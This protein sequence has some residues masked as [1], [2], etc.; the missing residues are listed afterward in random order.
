MVSGTAA[1]LLRVCANIADI[2]NSHPA[3]QLAAAVLVESSWRHGVELQRAVDLRAITF[4]LHLPR[5]E[6]R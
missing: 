5:A 2:V 6:A 1:A 4:G 3:L